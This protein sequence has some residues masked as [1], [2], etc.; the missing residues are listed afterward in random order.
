MSWFPGT[1]LYG[2]VFATVAMGLH[3]TIWTPEV[4]RNTVSERIV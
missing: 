4:L 3:V 1:H 2:N